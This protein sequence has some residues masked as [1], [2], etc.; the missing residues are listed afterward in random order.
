METTSTERDA[1][2]FSESIFG[3]LVRHELQQHS[4]KEDTPKPMEMEYIFTIFTQFVLDKME[5]RYD[6]EAEAKLTALKKI[7]IGA[8][9]N[10]AL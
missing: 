2:V 3:A 10:I 9:Q 4:D 7:F 5:E 1:L 8:K 6:I